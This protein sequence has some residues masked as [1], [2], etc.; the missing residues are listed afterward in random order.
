MIS[1]HI[2]PA[3]WRRTRWGAT[4]KRL[5][6]VFSYR[7]DAQLVP[8]LLANIDPVVDGWIAFDDRAASGVFS[9]EP[10]RRRAFLASAWAHIACSSTSVVL[11]RQAVSS[12]CVF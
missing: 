7:Y 2:K 8:G 1:R 5:L 4:R 6:A 11:A 9:S 12:A 3:R 10:A